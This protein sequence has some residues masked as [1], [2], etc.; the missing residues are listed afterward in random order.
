MRVHLA[1]KASD[2]GLL[3]EL[4][5]DEDGSDV[6]SEGPRRSPCS[7]LERP[8]RP[9]CSPEGDVNA[10]RSGRLVSKKPGLLETG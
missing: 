1:R 4:V 2:Q 10:M 6:L 3:E 9:P 8:L 7:I 5:D